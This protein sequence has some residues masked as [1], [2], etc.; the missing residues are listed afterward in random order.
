M[1]D[2]I[3]VFI[4]Y[5]DSETISY[6]ILCHSIWERASAPVRITPLRKNQIPLHRETHDLQTTSFAFSR[7]LIPHL[8]KHEGHAIYMD[9]DMLCLG[10]I[11]EL[12]EYIDHRSA[13]YVVQHDYVPSTTTKFLGQKQSVYPTLENGET[14]K[15]WSS[16]MLFNCYHSACSNLTPA[17]VNAEVD[18]RGL[19]LHQ[20]KWVDDERIGE[21]PKEWNYLIGEDNQCDPEKAK[22]LHWTLGAPCFDS[23]ID[24][25]GADLFWAEVDS[26]LSHKEADGLYRL[27]KVTLEPF[28][29]VSNLYREK[30]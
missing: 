22:L 17:F 2:M 25:Y 21:L 11:V 5:D 6:N 8:M 9:C 10:D 28:R 26:M 19:D 12:F 3:D 7:F 4:G 13:V 15:N 14:R 29:A 18:G 1:A 30:R 16:L 27:H 24:A 20:F 23:Y